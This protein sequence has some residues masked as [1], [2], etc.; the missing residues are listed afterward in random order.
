[1]IY[2]SKFVIGA[3]PYLE[4]EMNEPSERRREKMESIRG[5]TKTSN[6]GINDGVI[7]KRNH[8]PSKYNDVYGKRSDEISI[9]QIPSYK[10]SRELRQ[11]DE[12]ENS[13]E[14]GNADYDDIREGG[15]Y[16][17]YFSEESV[18][19]PKSTS[20][21]KNYN[22]HHKYNNNYNSDSKPYGYPKRVNGY[23]NE[24]SGYQRPYENKF[25]EENQNKYREASD[26]DDYTKTSYGSSSAEYSNNKSYKPTNEDRENPEANYEVTEKITEETVTTR[27]RGNYTNFYYAILNAHFEG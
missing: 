5:S 22:N 16:L 14:L 13:R 24:F 2:E 3:L 20:K 23:Q 25:S 11:S 12:R 15:G 26:E 8:E 6:Q 21:E 19:E 1:M 7:V 18:K 10:A 17:K 4:A 27:P 9:V